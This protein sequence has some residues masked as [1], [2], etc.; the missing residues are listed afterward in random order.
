MISRHQDLVAPVT[1]GMV[2]DERKG[3]LVY[4]AKSM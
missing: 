2:A 1:N 4:G 3:Q